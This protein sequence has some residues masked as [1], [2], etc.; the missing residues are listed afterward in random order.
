MKAFNLNFLP[1]ESYRS[2][3]VPGLGIALG[4]TY[5]YPYLIHTHY[6]QKVFAS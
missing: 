1:N 5:G 2:Y 3:K 6:F 4:D